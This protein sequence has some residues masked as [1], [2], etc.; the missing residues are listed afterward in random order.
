MSM[1]NEGSEKE[2]VDVTFTINGM[3]LQVFKKFKNYAK[4][5]RDNYSVTIQV[6]LE[7]ADMLE[8]YMTMNDNFQMEEVDVEEEVDKDYVRTM[9]DEE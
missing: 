6:L 1:L 2:P 9:G 5:W 4:D 3:P 7:K 8:Y